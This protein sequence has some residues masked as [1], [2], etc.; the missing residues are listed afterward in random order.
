MPI[1]EIIGLILIAIGMFFSVVGIVGMVRL[2]DVYNRIHA[3]GKV[4]F[5]GIVGLLAGVAVIMPETTLKGAALALFLIITTP[6][7]SHAIA[8]AAYRQ[9]VARANCVRDD[10]V[11]KEQSAAQDPA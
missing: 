10:L 1:N 9:G 2:P 11:A 3:T 4:S 8:A 6:V 5:L 7:A